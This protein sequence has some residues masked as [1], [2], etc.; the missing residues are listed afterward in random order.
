MGK[1]NTENRVL[2]GS[3]LTLNEVNLHKH[4]WNKKK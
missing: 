1:K 3:C 2:L 4:T